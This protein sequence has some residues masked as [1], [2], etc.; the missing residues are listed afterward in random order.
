[1]C[2]YMFLLAW[3][4]IVSNAAHGVESKPI[5]NISFYY[6]IQCIRDA[7]YIS[8]LKYNDKI[9]TAL[10]LL[11]P[12]VISGSLVGDEWN[13]NEEK[14]VFEVK[15]NPNSGKI[16][17]KGNWKLLEPLLSSIEVRSGEYC[18]YVDP[19]KRNNRLFIGDYYDP[20]KS[21]GTVICTLKPV[22]KKWEIRNPLCVFKGWEDDVV[23]YLKENNDE[24]NDE[25]LKG[26][27]FENLRKLVSKE[28]Q[29]SEIAMRVEHAKRK[30]S[31][32]I[33]STF[34]FIL[35]SRQFSEEKKSILQKII[36]EIKETQDVEIVH[37]IGCGLLTRHIFGERQKSNQMKEVNSAVKNR[38]KDI[39]LP[40]GGKFKILYNTLKRIR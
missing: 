29:P 35:F 11:R 1:M 36:D 31:Y 16:V 28:S 14:G 39:A 22:E 25:R 30:E 13:F 18:D 3:F 33:L 27:K 26:N 23:E 24:K 37:S 20:L 8:K 7:I 2:K 15:K 38:L 6:R 4:F 10:I 17:R 32:D 9:G 40:K 21:G 34:Y 5:N 12:N 19:P